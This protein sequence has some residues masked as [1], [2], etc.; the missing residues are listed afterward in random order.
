[1]QLPFRGG[2]V[3]VT[4]NLLTITVPLDR[5]PSPS[6]SGRS[7]VIASTNGFM[8]VFLDD[9]RGGVKIGLNVT[10]EPTLEEAAGIKAAQAAQKA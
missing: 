8:P 3:E 5:K 6:A 2:K 10:R 4:D 9:E 1:M 7:M